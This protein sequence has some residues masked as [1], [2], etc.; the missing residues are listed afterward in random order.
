MLTKVLNG[1]RLN[2]RYW[3]FA[4]AATNV[5]YR[6]EV[7]DGLKGGS[8]IYFNYIGDSSVATTDAAALQTCP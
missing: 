6:V 7:V 4:A 3:F 5:G 8:R 1:C 2:D